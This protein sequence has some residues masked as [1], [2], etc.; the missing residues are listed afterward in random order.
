MTLHLKPLLKTF[1]LFIFWLIFPPLFLTFSII[2]K[3][4]AAVGSGCT[5]IDCPVYRVGYIDWLIF[6]YEL[7]YFL[8]KCGD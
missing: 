3:N 1:A 2:W 7:L 8:F 5:S 4:A 6:G